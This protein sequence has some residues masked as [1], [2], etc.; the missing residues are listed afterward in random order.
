MKSTNRKPPKKKLNGKFADFRAFSTQ[1][2][3]LEIKIQGSQIE[4]PDGS[5]VEGEEVVEDV[6]EVDTV[7]Q[8][9]LDSLPERQG[10]N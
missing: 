6:E 8:E 10:P 1:F 4:G 9:Y 3:S 7:S 2:S 5:N